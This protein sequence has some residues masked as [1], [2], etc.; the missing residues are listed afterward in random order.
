MFWQEEDEK[1]QSTSVPDDIL[2]VSFSI[3]CKQLPIDHAWLLKAA[4]V[5]VLPW[6]ETEPLARI[7]PIH[8]AD[9]GNGWYRPENP[10]AELLIP[11]RRTKLYIRLPKTC[12]TDIEPLTGQTLSLGGYALTV[13][14][15]KIRLLQNAAVVFARYVACLAD[16]TEEQFLARMALE[17]RAK[18]G[19]KVKK[20][21]AG[22]TYHLDRRTTP[23]LTRQLMIADLD[24]DTAILLQQLGLG[25]E[26]L[27]G[28]G[29]VIPHKGIK[30]QDH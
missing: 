24:Q 12:F 16:E 10:Q 22:K 3:Q 11:S 23:L 20:M 1:P 14:E 19:F 13:G 8:V 9:S 17:V 26:G 29:V 30:A 7:H 15:P 5:K 21:L 4:L 27:M 25:T 2:D 18:T 6:L 28:C